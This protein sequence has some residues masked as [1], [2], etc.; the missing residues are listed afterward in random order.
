VTMRLFHA[1]SAENARAILAEGFRD[2]EGQYLP[3]L[4]TMAD[5]I[6]ARAIRRCGELLRAI[7]DGQGARTD[8]LGGG[9]AP[10]LSRAQAAREAG[11]SRDQKRDALRVA[12]VPGEEFEAAVESEDPPI[13]PARGGDR[14][15][16]KGG[17]V[18]VGETRT[19]AARAAARR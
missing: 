6:Q 9:A 18:P 14:G 5:R 13:E 8:K 15:G 4:R 1:T 11:L 3:A 2:S 12:N 7:K 10:K 16:P 17:R 19:S